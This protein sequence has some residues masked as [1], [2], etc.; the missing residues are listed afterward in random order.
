MQRGFLLGDST[1]MGKLRVIA[2]YILD[3]KLRGH[4]RALLVPVNTELWHETVREGL[5]PLGC[6]RQTAEFDPCWEFKFEFLTNLSQTAVIAKN[7]R[8]AFFSPRTLSWGIS[9]KNGS[10]R[11]RRPACPCSWSTR[12]TAP[13]TYGHPR[14]CVT[15]LAFST[16]VPLAGMRGKWHAVESWHPWH[17]R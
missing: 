5:A 7:Y 10:P 3:A 15:T 17:G 16:T 12:G 4:G 14:M 2:A 11:L 13:R 8:L 1:E 6:I 9:L